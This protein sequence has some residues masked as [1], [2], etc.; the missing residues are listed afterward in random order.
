[1]NKKD[2]VAPD[3]YNIVSEIEKYIADE[4]KK[5]IIFENAEGETHSI[6]YNQ[7]VKNANQVGNMFLKHGLQKGDK[8]L[9]MM[10]RSIET[11]EIYIAA[12]KLGIVVI[13]SSEMLRTKDLQYRISHGEVKAIVVTADSIDE[14]KAVKEYNTLTKFIVGGEYEDWYTVDSE[15][16]KEIDELQ[17]VE[18]SKDDVA[19]LSYTSGTTGNP[20]AV[21]H[22][23][24][25]GYAHMQMAPKH[26][27]SIKDDD[28]AWAT[29]APGWQKWVWSPFLSIM[30]SG[31]TAFVYNGKFNAEKYLE[32]LQD[33]KI[34]VLCCTPTEY[35]LMAK[36]PNLTDYNLEHLHSAVSAGE[37]LN[38]EVVEKFQT[39]FDLTVRDGYGQTES[40][41]LIGFLK[42]TESRPGSMGKAIPG[43]HVT[44][45][46][47]DGELAEIG[48]VGN[49][50]VPLDLPAL[51]KGYYKDPE[52][53]AEP[54]IGDYYIT[55]DLAKL[56]EDGYFWFEGRKDDIIIS[57]GYTIGPF[58]VEDSLTKHEYVKEC[59]VVAS[60]H[61]IRG[62]IVKAFIILQEG[63]PATDDTV[64]TLQDYVKQDVAP[65]KY[66]RAIE[67]VE[68]LPKTNSGKIR[69]IELRE[70]EK[71]K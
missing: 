43:S 56:D 67:F 30:G 60:P 52:R 58:E 13:P 6:T 65:Y 22:S 27:L 63:I 31:A 55:G 45:I 1:M 40:T 25:W 44:V 29:A 28:I 12:L 41:L 19:L 64:K 38:R 17:I 51:F 4:N 2:L 69:R 24:G 62:N 70:A 11:Y 54:R 36:L 10:P 68:D 42:D 7:L 5:A 23:H 14:F 9:V 33:Y 34:N 66:P 37:P 21:V 53:T 3:T 47:D 50:A 15:S 20:K 48:E 59:A 16:A 39:N 35:R 71:N 61:E 46:N 8:V 49:I 18:T 32:L 26:W 57:S